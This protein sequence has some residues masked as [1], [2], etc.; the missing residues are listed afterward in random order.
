MRK[1]TSAEPS[2]LNRSFTNASLAFFVVPPFHV[3]IRA[4]RYSCMHACACTYVCTL[5][6]KLGSGCELWWLWSQEVRSSAVFYPPGAS[7]IIFA[8]YRTK[9]TPLGGENSLE[10]AFQVGERISGMHTR[11]HT[12]T[13]TCIHM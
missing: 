9:A 13:H 2:L 5:R 3:L 8:S 1:P 12:H 10:Y 11:I 6:L 7:S 4:R